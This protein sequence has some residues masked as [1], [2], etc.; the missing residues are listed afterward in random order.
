MRLLGFV[1]RRAV[2]ICYSTAAI[3]LNSIFQYTYKYKFL[4]KPTESKTS[5]CVFL[6]YP[7]AHNL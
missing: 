6:L 1:L 2:E 3:Q 5:I 4:Q 7:L